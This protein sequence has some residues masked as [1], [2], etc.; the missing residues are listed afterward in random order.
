MCIGALGLLGSYT[1]LSRYHRVRGRRDCETY[2]VRGHGAQLS[3]IQDKI[4]LKMG[5]RPVS[6]SVYNLRV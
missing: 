4:R 6:W 3:E 5:E 2:F 1:V